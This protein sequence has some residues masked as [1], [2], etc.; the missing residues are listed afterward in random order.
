M[1]NGKQMI[2][3]GYFVT[4]DG[5]RKKIVNK[6]G[7][8]FYLNY[9]ECEDIF[10]AVLTSSNGKL[11]V[12]EV[13]PSCFEHDSF[14]IEDFL[15][16]VWVSMNCRYI[17]EFPKKKSKYKQRDIEDQIQEEKQNAQK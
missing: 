15:N 6:N 3:S 2:E 7:V 5:F 17:E 12:V 11:F 1:Y 9:F 14:E 8:K 4:E 16:K 13:L 10:S